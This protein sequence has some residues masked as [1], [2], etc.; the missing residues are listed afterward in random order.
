[1]CGEK[2][3]NRTCTFVLIIELRCYPPGKLL[4]VRHHCPF[5]SIAS[6]VLYFHIEKRLSEVFEYEILAESV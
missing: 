3:H 2:V 4:C 1:M 6:A 5:Y